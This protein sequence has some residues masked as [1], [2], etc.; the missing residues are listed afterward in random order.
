MIINCIQ[1]AYQ[2]GARV[3]NVSMGGY[4]PETSADALLILR[5]AMGIIDS[6]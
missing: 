4:Y 1:Y 3:A 6:F 5:R 2:H